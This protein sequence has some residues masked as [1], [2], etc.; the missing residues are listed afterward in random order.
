[1]RISEISVY[2][3]ELPLTE[4]RY[5]WSEGKH[6]DVFDSTVVRLDTDAGISGWGEACPLGPAY[7]PAFADGARA[8]IRT[9]APAL[10]GQDPTQLGV[11]NELMDR[12]LKGHPYA[13]SAL[14]MACWDLL[15]KHAGLP[16]VDLL[17]G[18]FGSRVALYRAIS[19]D[20]PERMAAR[21]AAYR[22][23]GYRRFQLKA[24]G[25]VSDDIERIRAAHSEL[26]PGDILVADA[27][28]GWNR[29]QAIQVIRGVRDLDVYIEQPC[30]TYAECLSVRRHCELPFV[31]DECMV[32]MESLARA[33]AD[34]AT[35]VVNLKISRFGGL[36]RAARAR[37]FCVA[38]G[39]PMTI[40]DS[41]GGDIVT[42][43]IA[44]LAHSTPERFRFTATDF[45]SYVSVSFAAGAPRR[46]NGTMAASAAPGL[47]VEPNLDALGEAVLFFGQPVR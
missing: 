39:T 16:C 42:A 19:Q 40:E 26:E 38:M 28:T 27:N 29:D 17:G 18:R 8:G 24:G 30:P 5:A 43:A 12:A 20:T 9:L 45:N 23:E 41:W 31:L 36:T 37:D 7:L 15:G 34:L 21:V 22:E 2:R 44:H 11:I 32:D 33:H 10:L 6:V 35:D 46:E 14:D 4:G 1:M 47:G 3:I 25:A 13:K